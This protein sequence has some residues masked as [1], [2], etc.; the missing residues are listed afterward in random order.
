[1]KPAWSF[2]STGS[3]RHSSTN[4]VTAF[5]VSSLA[6]SGRTT[7]TSDMA[8]TGLKKCTPQTRSGCE[9]CIARSMM[10]SVDVQVAMTVR[11]ADD[12]VER[13]KGLH[14][15]AEIL[16]HRFD[17]E[18]A[19]REVAEIGRHVDAS[20]NVGC[21]FDVALAFFDLPGE[22]Q[23]DGDEYRVSAG[24]GTGPYGHRGAR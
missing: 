8:D 12:G 6:V 19:R 23:V 11:R 10:G 1:M 5:I 7:S 21:V 18:I 16:D 20:A 2:T 4:S 13:T 14:L 3:F 15:D 9:T 24:S 22:R 17:H